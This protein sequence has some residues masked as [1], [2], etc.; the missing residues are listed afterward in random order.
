MLARDVQGFGG[1]G[2]VSSSPADVERNR[3]NWMIAL[4]VIGGLIVGKVIYEQAFVEGLEPHE[5]KNIFIAGAGTLLWYGLDQLFDI[6][7]QMDAAAE[8]AAKEIGISSW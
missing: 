7:K 6:Q 3:V 5:R 2:L 4:G 1:G 8:S